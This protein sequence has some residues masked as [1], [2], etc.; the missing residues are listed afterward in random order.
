MG[1]AEQATAALL[2]MAVSEAREMGKRGA[3][4]TLLGTYYIHPS[5]FENN[6]ERKSLVAIVCVCVCLSE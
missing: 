3:V 2:N 1:V 6:F 4:E 5:P